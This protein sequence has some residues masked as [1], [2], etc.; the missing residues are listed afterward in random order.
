MQLAS[1]TRMADKHVWNWNVDQDGVLSRT[2]PTTTESESGNS[3]TKTRKRMC[4]RR[5]GVN[6]TSAIVS[7]SCELQSDET[8][9]G[10]LVQFS[11]VRYRPTPFGPE[12]D[13]TDVRSQDKAET[14]SMAGH[15]S[16]SADLAHIKATRSSTV[17]Q[18]LPTNRP[19]HRIGHA[20]GNANNNNN[21]KNRKNEKSQYQKR[22]LLSLRD[23]NPILFTTGVGSDSSSDDTV[24]VSNKA[25]ATKPVNAGKT[26]VD[27]KVTTPSQQQP[28]NGSQFSG[29]EKSSRMLRMQTHPYIVAA[30]DGVWTDPKTGLEYPTDICEYLGHDHKEAGRHT[31]V[32]VGQYTKTFFSYA[33]K[34]YGIALYVSKRDVLADPTFERYAVMTDQELRETP[35]FHQ[36]LR[37]V[38]GDQPHEIQADRTLLLKLNMQLSTNT[39]RSSLAT[40]W[41]LLTQELKDLLINSSLKPRP[42]EQ[43]MLDKIMSAENSG[44]CSCG[45]VAPPEYKADI[46]C[47]ARGTELVFT[48]RKNGNLEV[49]LDGR[50]MDIFPRPDAAQ[51]IFFEY[52]R[53]DDPI[54]PDFRDRVVDGFPFL[55]APLAQVKGVASG[56]PVKQPPAQMASPKRPQQQQQ[57]DTHEDIEALLKA[58]GGVVDRVTSVGDSL[59]EFVHHQAN[60]ATSNF[61]NTVRSVGETAKHVGSGIDRRREQLWEHVHEAGLNFLSNR[62]PPFRDGVSSAL[63]NVVRRHRRRSRP[64]QTAATDAATDPKHEKTEGRWYDLTHP[65]TMV[66]R[67]VIFCLVH[68]YLMLLLI[69]SFPGSP[70]TVYRKRRNSLPTRKLLESSEIDSD[71][72]TTS[73]L[74][75]F[76]DDG[77]SDDLEGI[78]DMGKVQQA[79]TT[80][81][82]RREGSELAKGAVK[83]G[84]M[85][86]SLSYCL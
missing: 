80:T 17:S 84:E 27:G 3:N 74:D 42:A 52:L 34:V 2:T 32:G 8:D 75:V 31:L 77:E 39:M 73:S 16:T 70:E 9:D 13:S 82:T 62:V 41:K 40:D 54:S 23:T 63:K 36:H 37:S 58:V 35:E 65:N 78:S 44:R 66:P 76:D 7:S 56:R 50:V 6:G 24:H 53:Y 33:A 29:N 83:E 86:K 11:L 68:L 5:D 20:D 1:C 10:Y 49:R 48:W 43:P 47:C 22:S 19:I 57:R 38:P 18:G 26:R 30:K 55:L 25:D 61:V 46:S 14:P 71:A 4:I 45:Q 60:E 64:V 81:T 59:S 79:S 67:E 72:S 28:P 15:L 51:G 21:N 12:E 85:T 69:V